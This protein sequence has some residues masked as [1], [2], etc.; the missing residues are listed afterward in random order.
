[1]SQLPSELKLTLHA[2]ERLKE[3]KNNINYDIR[4]LMNGSHKWYG[5]DDLIP[6]SKLYIHAMY[7]CK[8]DRNKLGYLTDGNIEVLYDKNVNI[9]ITIM[10][11]KEKFLPITQFLKHEILKEKEIKKMRKTPHPIGICPDCGKEAGLTIHGICEKCQVRKINATRRGKEY[12]PYL[13]LPED[14][15]RKIDTYQAAQRKRN[16]EPVEVEVVM[17]KIQH[18]ENYYQAKASQNVVTS[19]PSITIVPKPTKT[20]VDSL[21]DP[22]GLVKILRGCGCEIPEKDLNDVLN[23]LISTDKLKD[24]FMTIA[25]ADCQQAMLDLE[26]ALNVVERKLQHD[27]EFNGFREEDDIKFKGFLSWR[28]VL[29]GAIFFWKKLYQTNTLIEL[30]RAWN[31]YTSDPGDKILLAGDRIDSK[32][33]RYQITT[34]SVSTIFNSRRPFTRVFYATSKEEA[35]KQFTKWMSDR[36]LHEDKSK[37]TI[38]ELT[39]LGEDGRKE[40]E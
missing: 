21:S 8:R 37:T 7:V 24:I 2:Q 1:M 35:Y 26:Q 16:E 11:V 29:K 14:K 17:P 5:M 9:V 18:P 13:S 36:Q 10:E 33:K 27:W 34:D 38:T 40:E 25:E 23:V 39:P 4:N 20:N 28:R 22:D 15:K 19:T 12:I 6:N 30:Q 3:R 31:S 32:M